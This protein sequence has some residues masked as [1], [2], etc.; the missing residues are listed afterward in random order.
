MN[1]KIIIIVFIAIVAIGAGLWFFEQSN[2]LIKKPNNN[3]AINHNSATGVNMANPASVYCV[4]QGGK[5]E[6]RED[7]DG[8]YGVCVMQN[9]VECDE[10]EFFRTYKC[11]PNSSINCSNLISAMKIDSC[12][13]KKIIATGTLQLLPAGDK[14]KGVGSII[15]DDNTHLRL[16]EETAGLD[17]Y[18]NQKIEILAVLHKCDNFDQCSG[19][20]LTKI[21]AFSP[22]DC[23]DCGI[24]GWAQMDKQCGQK[25]AAKDQFKSCLAGSSLSQVDQ[26][27]DI[28]QIEEG[29]IEIGGMLV[30]GKPTEYSIKVFIYKQ[31]AVDADG[32]LYLL[33]MPG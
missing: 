33:G 23:M 2:K 10:W 22:T 16:L 4:K 32:N 11:S 15:F 28:S 19:I 25:I 26:N 13:N 7:K 20:G 30:L 6:I 21:E 12:V 31:W 5:S 18:N 1:K 3:S 27:T 24:G 14:A 8:Q 17:K 29:Y 9:G